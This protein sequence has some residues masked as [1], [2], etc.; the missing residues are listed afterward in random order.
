MDLNLGMAV[1]MMNVVVYAM[2]ELVKY[3]EIV[4][5]PFIKGIKYAPGVA[6]GS[7]GKS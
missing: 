7:Y 6:Q 1:G 3:Q 4:A 5:M 2:Q